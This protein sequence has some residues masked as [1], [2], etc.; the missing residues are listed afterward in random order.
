MNIDALRYPI[1]QYEAP[2]VFTGVIIEDWINELKIFPE[3]FAT[4]AES[5]SVH[6]LE[7]AYRPEGWTARQVI[8]H[9]A[10]SH[11]NAFIRFKLALTEE[12]PTIK[13]Y[14][15]ALWANMADVKLPVDVSLQIIRLVH[16]RW[17]AVLSAM[18][19]VDFT[20]TYAHPQYTIPL[21]LQYALGLYVWHS[22]H[23]HAHLDLC[24]QAT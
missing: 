11:M 7:T 3:K 19:P 16:T 1:G 2:E 5:L 18:T 23:H 6:E 10:D 20:R 22:R 17:D 14:K 15:E 13:P 12:H 24:R 4:T 21:T 8:H 9:V